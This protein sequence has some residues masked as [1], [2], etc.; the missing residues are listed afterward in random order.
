MDDKRIVE[1]YWQRDEAAI[2]ET[3]LQYDRYLTKIAYNILA[4]HEDS[5]ESVN[6]TYLNAWNSMPPHKPSVL[7][8][9]LGKI[10][11]Q[12]AIDIYRKRHSQ[13]RY[14]SQYAL[15]LDELSDCIGS[16][17]TPEQ[18][19]ELKHLAAA[20][21]RY[22][23]SLSEEMRNIFVC[24]YFFLDSIRDIASYYSSSQSRIKSILHRTRIG[25][26]AYL[27]KEGYEI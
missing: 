1:L 3:Q 14:P 6:D 16:G 23:H 18:E 22:L 24:R 26:K 13:K 4:N 11:R 2:R 15:S 10:T 21:N 27:E 20:I 25:L 5:K 7:A 19:I 9:Y 12:S 8:T 17:S